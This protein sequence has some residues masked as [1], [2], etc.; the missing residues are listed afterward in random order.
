M[1]GGHSL[2]GAMAARFVDEN[3]GMLG[4]LALWAGY[5]AESNSLAD[6]SIAVISIS[7]TLDGLAK[8]EKDRK[9]SSIPTRR[10]RIRSD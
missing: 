5:P 9:F 7:G 1:I 2:G 8:C 3:P 4:G 10:Y 6:N